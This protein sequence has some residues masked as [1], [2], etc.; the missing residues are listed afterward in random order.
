MNVIGF[1]LFI[2]M[3]VMV[4]CAAVGS[5]NTALKPLQPLP[6]EMNESSGLIL[7]DHDLYLGLNDSGNPAEL[8]LFSL[9]PD[10]PLRTIQ[11]L[12]A[13]NRD[14]E[15]L[16]DDDEYIYIGDTGNNSG[17]RKDLAIY[18][19]PKSGLMTATEVGAERISFYYPEQDEYN[20]SRSHNFDCEA[21]VSLGDSLYLFTKNRG[22]Q[23]TDFYRLP[24]TP[25]HYPAIW[26]GRFDAKGLVT[27]ADIRS[28]DQGHE[29]ALIGYRMNRGRYQAFLLIFD[30]QPSSHFFSGSARRIDLDVTLQTETVLFYDERTVLI[31]NEEEHGDEGF[32]YLVDIGKAK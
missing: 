9:N 4:A 14:W 27:G 29:L 25:G 17:F 21:M 32:M 22:D 31:T 23:Q 15:E 2:S 10:I 28:T 7:L 5:S 11:V 26:M 30:P 18:R 1:S 6:P 8:Y 13:T 16:A 24:K 20:P 3:A 12:G 19:V